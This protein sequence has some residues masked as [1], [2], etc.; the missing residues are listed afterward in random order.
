MN[1]L[2][3]DD[4]ALFRE[5]LVLVLKQLDDAENIIEAESAEQALSVIETYTDNDNDFDLILLDVNLPN[6]PDV[7][8][9]L[10]NIK[11]LNPVIPVAI[12]SAT[13]DSGLINQLLQKGASGF[14]TKSSNSQ[15]TLSAVRLILS[16]GLYVPHQALAPATPVAEN[17]PSGAPAQ[18]KAAVQLTARQKD[19]FELL[20][21][22]LSNKEIA[23][24]LDMSPSTVKVHVAA[25]LRICDVSN[26]TQAVTYAQTHSLL[27]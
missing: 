10:N 4:H 5:G 9:T 13:E 6:S 18:S 23:R 20:A 11:E 25:I 2:V 8:T 19:V 14:I 3:I 12:L 15:V 1:I 27:G 17:Q 26:R 21:E 22:G 24:K 7:F 16:G